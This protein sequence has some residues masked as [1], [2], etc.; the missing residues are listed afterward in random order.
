MMKTVCRKRSKEEVPPDS[1]IFYEENVDKETGG[2]IEKRP[3]LLR[4]RTV[5]TGDML[6][7]AQPQIDSAQYNQPYVSI[8]F[9]AKGAKIFKDITTKHVGKRLAIVLDNVVKSAPVIREPIA[10]GRAQI[11]GNFT[12]EE[13]KTWQ[14][15]CGQARSPHR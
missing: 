15:S 4:K 14:L 2:V 7:D 8:K 9:N 10:G 12:L 6:V 5:L 3:L 11:E 1:E 13:L